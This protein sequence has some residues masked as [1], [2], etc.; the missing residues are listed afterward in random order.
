[1][2][3]KNTPIFPDHS[4]L[5]SVVSSD[6]G[7]N[8]LSLPCHFHTREG[9]R[10]T[11][12]QKLTNIVETISLSQKFPSLYPKDGKESISK[13]K[14]CSLLAGSCQRLLHLYAVPAGRIFMFAPS[15]VGEIFDLS[16]VQKSTNLSISLKVLS[17]TPRIFD[18]VNFF[19]KEE[20]NSIVKRAL[21]ETSDTHKLKR[22]STG[23]SGYNI[24]IHRT[25]ENGFDTSGDVAMAIKKRCMNL[26]GFDEYIES[27]TDGLQI[28][29]YNKTAAY[30]SHLDYIEDPE[31]REE[32]NYDS[33][34][35][36]SNRFATVL[37]YMSDLGEKDGGETM[38]TKTWSTDMFSS[39]SKYYDQALRELR[40]S[41]G[42]E[43]LKEGSWEEKMVAECRSGKLVIRPMNTRAV[44]FYSQHP[45]GELDM[46]SHHGSCPVLNG[47][48]WAA[49]LWVWNA[50]RG[51]YAFAPVNKVVVE[52][53]NI[54]NYEPEFNI[55]PIQIVATF[56]NDGKNSK[57]AVSDLYYMDT[58]WG[59]LSHNN[60]PLRVNTYEGHVW[61]IKAKN[62]TVL[63]RWIINTEDHQNFFV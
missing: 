34:G 12:F 60:P 21:T 7:E 4:K 10:I 29:R 23:A 58:Y 55:N 47:N 26:L 51:G 5:V 28:L 61:N 24:N 3:E 11:S 14:S 56:R 16:H 59:P 25:S 18:I 32:H 49:N 53:Q 20:S 45:N 30:I 9:I 40:S 15:Y 41:G 31:K 35:V 17:L 44:L 27:F 48:K 13:E 2:G 50:P 1:M 63:K 62:G 22:S 36:G 33:A 37:L 19:D 46:S 38:F 6:N 8:I 43:F 54:S 42:P 57:F 39:K 52:R